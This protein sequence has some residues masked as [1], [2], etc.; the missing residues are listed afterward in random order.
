MPMFFAVYTFRK[1]PDLQVS[2]LEVI[3]A[4]DGL[5]KNTVMCVSLWKTTSCT[6]PKINDLNVII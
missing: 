4:S 5:D 2:S 6:T 1:T 3:T